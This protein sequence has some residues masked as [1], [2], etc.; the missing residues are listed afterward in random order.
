MAIRVIIDNIDNKIKNVWIWYF[1]DIKSKNI[2][3][4]KREAKERTISLI[5]YRKQVFYIYYMF[6]KS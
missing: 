5:L 6:L 2:V 4:R 1:H 3:M